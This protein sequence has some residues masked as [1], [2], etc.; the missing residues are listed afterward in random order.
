MF[1]NPFS[2][3]VAIVLI[4]SIAGVLRARWGL[5]HR[6]DRHGQ[7]LPVV[8]MAETQRL[9]EE[10]KMLKD[11]V[12]VLERIATDTHDTVRIEQEIAK[13]RDS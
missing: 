4:V 1:N 9:R 11:R 7:T 6:R 13:L 2:M 5:P 10:V 12:A 8:D 3:V